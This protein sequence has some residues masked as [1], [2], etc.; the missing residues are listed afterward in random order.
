MVRSGFQPCASS[1]PSPRATSMM[2]AVPEQIG[3]VLFVD[4]NNYMKMRS[5]QI[6]NNKKTGEREMAARFFILQQEMKR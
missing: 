6:N 1:A 4:N 3:Y 2:V 5:V